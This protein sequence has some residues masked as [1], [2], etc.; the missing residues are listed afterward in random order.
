ME[1]LKDLHFEHLMVPVVQVVPALVVS[2]MAAVADDVHVAP[3]APA[4]LAPVLTT[5][6]AV[7]AT[8]VRRL[9]HLLGESSWNN[10]WRSGRTLI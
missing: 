2:T 7:P 6:V 4:L 9:W 3:G 10:T 8:A 1:T 5:T